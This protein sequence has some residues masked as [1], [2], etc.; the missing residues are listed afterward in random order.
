MAIAIAVGVAHSNY[1]GLLICEILMQT[2]CPES[3][4]ITMIM[5]QTNI[6]KTAY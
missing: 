1:I 6:V 2:Q 4:H 5:N 3:R